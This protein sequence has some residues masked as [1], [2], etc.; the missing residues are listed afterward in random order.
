MAS[1]WV[2]LL[3]GNVEMCDFKIKNLGIKDGK[4]A[5]DVSVPG[6]R[7]THFQVD[8]F[9]EDQMIISY[10]YWWIFKQN[11]L[12]VPLKKSSANPQK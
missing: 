2:K 5:V 9:D 8:Y 4:I 11:L 10:R 12:H 3:S 6:A 7:F 1:L